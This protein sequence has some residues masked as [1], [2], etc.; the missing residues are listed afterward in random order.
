M[1]NRWLVA[2][3][4]LAVT[5]CSNFER[6]NAK[7][8]AP[9][10]EDKTQAT[11]SP[12]LSDFEAESKK[13]DDAM[14]DFMT[15]YRAIP[16]MK[17]P[18]GTPAS[19]EKI[20]AARQE[21]M[22]K[23]PQANDYAKKMLA[24]A[25]EDP[26][27]TD[28]FNALMWVTQKTRSGQFYD[29][30]LEKLTTDFIAREELKGICMGLSY[31]PSSKEIEERLNLLIEKSP[32]DSVKGTATLAKA[33]YL[34]RAKATLKRLQASDNKQNQSEEMLAYLESIDAEPMTLETLY[35]SL[36]N[37]YGDIQ[38]S[39]RRKTT[40]KEMATSALFEMKSLAIGMPV[41]DIQGEDIE[42]VEFKLS[43]YR[44]KVVVID[45]WGD[46]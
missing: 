14:S 40:L 20:A 28:A 6:A 26:Q 1:K 18:D 4:C 34:K 36:I 29:A 43:D 24:I 16:R 38:P 30:A 13:F 25:E 45:F 37:D 35:E 12:E 19:K 3:L 44:G 2:L 21:A 42:G 46:W 27:G 15:N 41:P 17:N 31:A 39:E 23:L 8:T 32:H 33:N 11:E 5:A 7:A 9:T 22:K 10:Q